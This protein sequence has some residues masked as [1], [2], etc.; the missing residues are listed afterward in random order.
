MYGAEDCGVEKDGLHV[1]G[2]IRFVISFAGTLRG[3]SLQSVCIVG[4]GSDG[5]NLFLLG[6]KQVVDLFEIFVM[7]FLD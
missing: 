2:N 7:E 3:A 5:E 4:W 1:R 6:G